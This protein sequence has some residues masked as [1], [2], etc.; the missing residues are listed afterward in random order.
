MSQGR[1]SVTVTR[2]GPGIRNVERS[3]EELRQS[4]VYVGIPAENEQ[5]KDD[6]INNASLL[7][8][9]THGSPINHIPP[10]PVL[11]PAIEANRALITP[12]LAAAARAVIAG[13]AQAATA[14]LR[15]AG[16]IGANAAK[17][18]F[19]D[20]RNGWAPNAPSTIRAKGSDK[21]L[22]DTGQLRRAITSIVSQRGKTE[23]FRKLDEVKTTRHLPHLEV[24]GHADE[25]EEVESTSGQAVV[26]DPGEA[27]TLGGDIAEVAGE[28]L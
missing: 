5:R 3:L 23:G 9:H 17:R 11:E 20:P 12:E 22:I 6:K 10:R 14:H 26:S 7:F 4:E 25:G 1:T 15:R 27:A 13:D 18:W 21:P 24:H 16:I 8:L 2:R 28:I 19:T